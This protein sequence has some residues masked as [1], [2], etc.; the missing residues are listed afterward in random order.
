MSVIVGNITLQFLQLLLQFGHDDIW[1]LCLTHTKVSLKWM[2]VPNLEIRSLHMTL[3]NKM[4]V[5]RIHNDI[6]SYV[7]TKLPQNTILRIIFEENTMEDIIAQE[8]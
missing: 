2:K 5:L 1:A 3:Q 7:C 4:C 8:N 6:E